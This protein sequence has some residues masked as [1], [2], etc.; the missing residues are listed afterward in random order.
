HVFGVL[1]ELDARDRRALALA[2]LTGANRA[3]VASDVGLAGDELGAALARARK[4]LRRTRVALP[5]AARC[6]RAERLHSE[7]LDG[8]LGAADERFLDAHR[9]R[10]PRCREHVAGLEAALE[11]LRAGFKQAERAR[12]RAPKAPVAEPAAGTAKLRVVPGPQPVPEPPT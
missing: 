6:E 7:R 4:A 12:R 11:E 3:A 5:A 1:G 9:G 8:R 10:C 2:E